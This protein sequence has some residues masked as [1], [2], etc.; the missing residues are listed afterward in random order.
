MAEL[1]RERP[2]DSG[3]L[4][5]KDQ[6]PAQLLATSNRVLGL[7]TISSLEKPDDDWHPT[8]PH[9]TNHW[10]AIA[11]KHDL[12]IKA[13]GSAEIETEDGSFTFSPGPQTVA[14]RN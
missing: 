4:D 3:D 8:K 13:G 12:V 1:A 2:E 5:A 9:C 14:D 11:L 6:E 7:Q 10:Q